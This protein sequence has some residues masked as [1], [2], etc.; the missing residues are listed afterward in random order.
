MKRCHRCGYEWIST[1]KQPAVKEICEGCNAY[2]HCCFNCRFRRP[3]ANN[4]CEI[5]NT[6]W[7]ADRQGCNFCDEFEFKDTTADTGEDPRQSAA[8][9]S[10]DALL[11][12]GS[13]DKTDVGAD[14]FDKL[15]DE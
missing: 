14:A 11:G 3:P 7:V 10:F 13:E 6:D 8:R 15:F 12:G 4:Q 5:P 1:L 2:L 9:D